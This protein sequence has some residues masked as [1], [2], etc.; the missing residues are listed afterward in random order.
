MVLAV[1]TFAQEAAVT[2][3]SATLCVKDA[4]DQTTLVEM[5]ALERV[6]RV[7]A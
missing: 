1:E 5:E 6:S 7:E 2:R 4:E 3:D